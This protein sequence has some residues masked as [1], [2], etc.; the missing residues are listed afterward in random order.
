MM[1]V[2]VGIVVL[3]VQ[4]MDLLLMLRDGVMKKSVDAQKRRASRYKPKEQ[5]QD[6]VISEYLD[7]ISVVCFQ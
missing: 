6:R 5:Q 7:Y 2:V 1:N 3:F 4:R